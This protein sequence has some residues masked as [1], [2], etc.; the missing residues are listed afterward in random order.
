MIRAVIFAK[1]LSLQ[2]AH[3]EGDSEI[4]IKAIQKGVYTYMK[5]C[6]LCLDR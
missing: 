1:E 6:S 3:F 4:V 2:Q 5:C